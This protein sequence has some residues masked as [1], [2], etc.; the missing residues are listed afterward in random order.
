MN[1]L[2]LDQKTSCNRK[3][4]SA[5]A[6]TTQLRE[7]KLTSGKGNALHPRALTVHDAKCVSKAVTVGD[8]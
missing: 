4:I 8:P 6:H 7:R 1:V 3:H 2:C 5:L